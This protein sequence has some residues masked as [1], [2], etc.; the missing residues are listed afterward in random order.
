MQ[1]TIVS[2]SS[3]IVSIILLVMGNAYLMTLLGLRLSIE[4]LS[5]GVIGWI[6]AFYSIGFVAGTL[7]STRLYFSSRRQT[8]RY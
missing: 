2:L 8:V 4:D 3:L 7:P 5:A 1:R 6:L